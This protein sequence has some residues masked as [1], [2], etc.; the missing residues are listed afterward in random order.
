MRNIAAKETWFFMRSANEVKQKD[1]VSESLALSACQ[2]VD[3]NLRATLTDA[4]DGVLRPGMLPKI[5][6]VGKDADKL[7]QSALGSQAGFKYL[8]FSNLEVTTLLSKQVGIHKWCL[9]AKKSSAYT[10]HPATPG[11]CSEKGPKTK[12]SQS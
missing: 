7:M 8:E 1:I 2:R 10:P 4:S 5:G 11:G 12:A 3:S 9:V 6:D